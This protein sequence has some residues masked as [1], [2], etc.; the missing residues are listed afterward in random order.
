MIAGNMRTQKFAAAAFMLFTGERTQSVP[1]AR[2]TSATETPRHRE[3]S[4]NLCVFVSPWLNRLCVLFLL[5][6]SA[7]MT[8]AAAAD[9]VPAT[10]G[11]IE[12]TPFF[13]S[14]VQIEHA[15]KVI[16][17]DPWSLGDLSRAKPADLILVTDDVG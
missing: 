8:A 13:H 1:R 4:E 6:V 15:G 14:S 3:T 12:I 17:V 9:K 7:G 11:D 2:R 5:G 10:G 16:Q